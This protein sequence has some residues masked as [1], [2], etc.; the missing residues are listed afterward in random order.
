MNYYELDPENNTFSNIVII[1]NKRKLLPVFNYCKSKQYNIKVIGDNE[2]KH[3]N[4]VIEL[5]SIAQKYSDSLFYDTFPDQIINM[6]E[7]EKFLKLETKLN[8]MFGLEGDYDN[9]FFYSKKKQD[10]VFKKL[11]IPTVPNISDTVI[12]KTDISGGTGFKV[13]DGKNA[14][15]FFQDYLEI[16]YIIS[17]HLYSDGQTWYHLNNHKIK[18]TNNCPAES[19]TPYL[20][21]DDYNIISLSIEK[22][23]KNLHIH[24][25]LFGWQFLKDK[26]GNLYSIDFNL[27]PFGGFDMGSYD[28]DVSDQNWC[29]YIFG[30]TP[31]EYINYHSQVLCYYL[32]ARQFGYSPVRRIKQPLI[33]MNYEVK[34][35]DSIFL[36]I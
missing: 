27:R 8:R 21:D 14:L 35:Y 11:N 28:T 31:P 6:K 2:L 17:C 30:D 12:M 4:D 7:Q 20:L 34:R 26:S 36:S 1:G 29:S 10:E 15:G 32:E 25:K 5:T 9:S 33:Q 23:A 22:L 3:E 18:Y 24:N 13:C 19:V 16:D